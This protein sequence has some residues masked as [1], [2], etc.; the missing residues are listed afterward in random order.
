[1]WFTLFMNTFLPSTPTTFA[2]R[3]ALIVGG[4]CQA[5]AACGG[6]QMVGFDWQRHDP[7]IVPLVV[8][9]WG[10]LRRLVARFEALVVRFAAGRVMPPRLRAAR[11]TTPV[12]RAGVV[13]P[14][15]RGWLLRLL[16]GANG[17]G[18]Q[19]QALLA[20]PGMME[21]VAACPQAGRILRPLCRMLLV[22]VADTPLALVPRV[23]PAA[24]A[25]VL[26]ARAV[27]RPRPA[28]RAA[29]VPMEV[30]KAATPGGFG[31][32]GPPGRLIV[33]R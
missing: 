25:V 3:L 2:Q 28:R 7:A 23:R 10:R 16:P 27:S 9:I 29:V 11:A 6:R 14:S 8:P 32:T 13:L 26:R 1:M 18:G 19:L 21:F 24:D 31:R 17:A 33:P 22:P 15:E 4:L 12:R 20:E 30:A 5:V